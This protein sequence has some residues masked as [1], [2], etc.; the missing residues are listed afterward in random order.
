MPTP[1]LLS[2]TLPLK[3]AGTVAARR[4]LPFAG[5]VTEAES[6]AVLSRMK[7]TALPEK[8]LPARSVAVA[9]L[10]YPTPRSSDL[11]GSVALLGQ[12]AALLLVVALLLAAKATAVPTQVLPFQ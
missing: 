11:A 8:L 9:W 6:G 5:V 2:A 1:P 4:K 10:A 12:V 7:E 3:L